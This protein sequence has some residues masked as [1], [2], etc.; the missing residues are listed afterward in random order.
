[1]S[2]IVISFVSRDPV[3]TFVRHCADILAILA[4]FTIR[5]EPIVSTLFGLYKYNHSIECVRVGVEE[6]CLSNGDRSDS[7]SG[8]TRVSCARGQKQWRRQIIKSG[9]AFK[10]QL[11]FQVGQME[12]KP[13]VGAALPLPRKFVKNQL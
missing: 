6:S 3:D 2:C 8:V 7:G 9:S 13:K 5:A 10:G 12:W 11:Y 4:R 1:M